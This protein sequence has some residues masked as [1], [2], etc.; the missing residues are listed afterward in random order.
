MGRAARVEADACMGFR[1]MFRAK[2][3]PH[4]VVNDHPVFFEWLIWHE[5]DLQGT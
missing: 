1:G 3:L 5:T 2:K 4:D